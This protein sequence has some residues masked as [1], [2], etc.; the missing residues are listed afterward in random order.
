MVTL[1]AAIILLAVGLPFFGGVVAN[2]RAVA[3]ANGFLTSLRLAR[4]EAV[5]RAGYVAVAPTS[6]S[7]GWEGGWAVYEESDRPGQGNYGT[8][9]GGETVLRR[10]SE[11]SATFTAPAF[12]AFE[13][14]GE[15]S[16]DTAPADVALN[17]SADGGARSHCV[18][19]GRSGLIRMETYRPE[20]PFNQTCP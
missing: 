1:A 13:P 6:V 11:V 17:A 8:W 18:Q 20:S 14:S 16:E 9:Q 19:I 5:K 2:N 7:A 15:A 3:E 10:W 4:S 12:V